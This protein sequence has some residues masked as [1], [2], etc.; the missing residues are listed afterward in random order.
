VTVREKVFE[1]TLWSVSPAKAASIVVEPSDPPPGEYTTE[2]LAMLGPL[3]LRVHDDGL[4][5]PVLDEL[6]LTIP[7]GKRAVPGPTSA[8]VAVH[9]L[10]LP[11]GNDDGEQVT[12][13]VVALAVTGREKAPV[14]P[15]WSESPPYKPVIAVVPSEPGPGTYV[16]K[17]LADKPVTLKEH[18]VE[19]NVPKEE[20][21]NS[22]NPEGITA[23]PEAASV[24]E[25]VHVLWTSTCSGA[26]EH[27]TAIEVALAMTLSG[28]IA[29]ALGLL[30]S[31][32]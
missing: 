31:P 32:P 2:Q 6:K 27:D 14:E 10:G 26:G 16:T 24:T 25:A 18:D 13:R 9:A 3:A 5:E 15:E 17:Q 4:N 11:T 20:E 30:P 29:N 7:V 23:V 21:L 28:E 12:P 22:T 1:V 19:L 8:T